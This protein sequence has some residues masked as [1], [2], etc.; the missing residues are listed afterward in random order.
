MQGWSAVR[1]WTFLAALLGA[2]ICRS[3]TPPTS[4]PV[5]TPGVVV[6]DDL[7]ER[8]EVLLEGPRPEY[9]PI[10]AGSEIGDPRQL[11][12][13]RSP[14]WQLLERVDI[15]AYHSRLTV[16]TLDWPGNGGA[17][18]FGVPGS[19]GLLR[20]VSV[21]AVDQGGNGVTLTVA[22]RFTDPT[23]TRTFVLIKEERHSRGYYVSEQ[24]EL[25]HDEDATDEERGYIPPSTETSWIAVAVAHDRA[26]L[27]SERIRDAKSVAFAK[28]RLQ[29]VTFG[30]TQRTYEI[31]IGVPAGGPRDPS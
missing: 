24:G 20:I 29:L 18:V 1:S 25:S 27:A 12:E 8:S 14:E 6:C 2:A 22:D 15:A 13:A 28:D 11:L 26:W 19:Q 9:V 23:C 21:Y 4:A 10:A 30:G 31:S 7:P 5:P 17:L 16:L 3:E